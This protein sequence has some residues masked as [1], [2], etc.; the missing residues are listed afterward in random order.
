MLIVK[1]FGGTSVSDT[2]KIKKIA[3]KIKDEKNDDC[4]IVVVVSAMGNT[5]DKFVSL[6]K[7]ISSNPTPREMD[8]LLSSGERITMSLLAIALEEIGV[9]SL[10]LTGSQCE[11][12]TSSS[13]TNAR[14]VEIR[15][16]RIKQSLKQN[17]VVIVAGFQGVSLEKEITTLGRGGSDTTAVA[18]ACAM[19]ADKCEI[20]TDVDGIFTA[21]P[22]YI[23]SAKKLDFISYEQMIAMAYSGSGVMHTRALEIASNYN[24]DIEVKSSFTLKKGTIIKKEVKTLENKRVTSITNMDNLYYCKFKSNLKQ[25]ISLFKKFEKSGV[26]IFE[27]ELL[28]ENLSLVFEKKFKPAIFHLLK[29]QGLEKVNLINVKSVSLIGHSISHNLSFVAQVL[30]TIQ[31]YNIIS[32]NRGDKDIT[33]VISDEVNSQELIDVLHKRFIEKI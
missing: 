1:K 7:E 27:Y 5:T 14:I 18:I 17:R 25:R 24:I 22:R 6:A 28:D 20:Y 26:D 29:T 19:G 30:E 21:D 11:I 9:E 23:K 13:H 32:V 8:I 3:K 10:S 15:A 31:N 12:I 2:D 33:I 16:T 4:S